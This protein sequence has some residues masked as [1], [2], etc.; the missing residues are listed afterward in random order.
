M[1]LQR[2][3]HFRGNPLYQTGDSTSALFYDTAEMPKCT[4]TNSLMKRLIRHTR[5]FNLRISVR[6][7]Y[8]V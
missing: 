6:R 8:S 1:V 2:R 4:V 7:A 5:T 3:G